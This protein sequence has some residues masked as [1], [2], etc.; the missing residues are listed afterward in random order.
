MDP[1]TASKL[2]KAREK[3][4]AELATALVE[5]ADPLAAYDS[6]V[7]WT[8]DNY[9]PGNLAQSGLLELLEEATRHFVDDDS[10]KSDLRYL[11]L[12]LLYANHVEDPTMIYAFVFSKDIG[13]I[14]AQMY[15]EFA[16]ALERKGR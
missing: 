16:D 6:F 10:Y 12:W 5:D 14:Y 13:K 15:W 11:K 2:A 1:A 4:R 8:L 3:Y 7:K 9:G